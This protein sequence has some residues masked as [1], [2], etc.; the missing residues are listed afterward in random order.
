MCMHLED[1]FIQS[2]L[3]SDTDTCVNISVKE[4]LN[5]LVNQANTIYAT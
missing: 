3:A 5:D 1:A 4:V 2:L